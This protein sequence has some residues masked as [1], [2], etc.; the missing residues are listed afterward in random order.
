M[1]GLFGRNGK[2]R[3]EDSASRERD[4]LFSFDA[5][6]GAT[7]IAHHADGRHAR[8]RLAENNRSDLG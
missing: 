1:A 2:K 7:K 5:M 3:D 8:A 6:I 4:S